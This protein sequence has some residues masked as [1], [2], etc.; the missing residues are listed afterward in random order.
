[1]FTGQQCLL[2]PLPYGV[3]A[4]AAIVV[5]GTPVFCGGFTASGPVLTCY[6]LDKTT[7]TW[8]QVSF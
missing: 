7:K 8:M 6:S 2:S 1:M 5:D 3:Q 4:Q